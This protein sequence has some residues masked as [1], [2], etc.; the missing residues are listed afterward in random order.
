MLDV[1]LKGGL[2]VDGT[3]SSPFITDIAFADDRVVRIGDCSEHEAAMQL[4]C[5][6]LAVTPGFID[7]HSH[8]DEVLLVLPTAD[9]KIRQGITTEVGGNCGFSPAPLLGIAYNEKRDDMRRHYD[10][11]PTWTDFNGFFRALEQSPPA[12]NFCCL[13]GLGT[14]RCAI[15]EIGAAPLDR[16]ATVR[17]ERLVRDACEQ[18][19]IGISSGLI[20][21]PGKSADTNE[22]IALASAASSAGSSLYASHI[23]S[24][25]DG[26]IEAVDE[27][28]EIGHTS[29]CAVQLSHRAGRH[30]SWRRQCR[31]A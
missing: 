15:G 18:G 6:G 31:N 17:A 11:E 29:G 27:A 4:D 5:S 28:L 14:I 3:G 12:L 21:P 26:L 10:V 7:M 30:P 13:A 8:S 22:L 20:Y 24:E 19:A 1:V 2:I 9:G 25:G 16:D 23:R